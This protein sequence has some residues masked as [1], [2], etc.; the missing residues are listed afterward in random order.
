MAPTI[1][2]AAGLAWLTGYSGGPPLTLRG[3][4]DP[5]AGLHAAFAILAAIAERDGTGNGHVIESSMIEAGLNVA[6]E[7]GIEWSAYGASICRD[8]NR[9]PVGTPQGVYACRGDD[10]WLALAVVDDEQWHGLRRALGKPEWAASH[11]LASRDGRRRAHDEL[12]RRLAEW[13][14]RQELLD[15]VGLLIDNGV[16][17]APVVDALELAANEQLR[18]RGYYEPIESDVIGR[19]LTSSLPFRFTSRT[20]GWI[21]GPAPTL[22]QHTREV[23]TDMLSLDDDRLDALEASG[24]IG[25]Q[26]VG[27]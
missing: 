7:L 13:S 15:A 5:I 6:A 11:E 25:T 14:A 2:V 8:G 1:E 16:P 4:G 9:G 21:R 10:R 23:L 20:D 27:A 18:A 17:A 3:P 24:V 26:P 19:H 12:D 22:G